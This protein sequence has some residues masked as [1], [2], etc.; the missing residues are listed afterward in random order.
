[1]AFFVVS[2]GVFKDIAMMRQSFCSLLPP[3]KGWGR[4]AAL[5][6]RLNLVGASFHLRL[7]I[8]LSMNSFGLLMKPS[9]S[10]F[11]DVRGLRYH[12]RSWGSEGAPRIF[13]LHGMNDVSA[14]FQFIVDELRGD[15]RVLA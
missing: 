1:M 9:R 3:G 8:Q 14:S 7:P 5:C 11:V 2:D 10:L 13:M 6:Y 12:V 15:W 4:G